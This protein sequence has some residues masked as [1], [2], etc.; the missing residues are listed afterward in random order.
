MNNADLFDQFKK[1]WGVVVVEVLAAEECAELIKALTKINRYRA[2]RAEIP[3]QKM[4][5]L[6]DELADVSICIEHLIQVHGLENRVAARIKKKLM[7]L[8]S[9][10]RDRRRGHP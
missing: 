7:R 2:A 8:A 10:V 6:V 4:T 9:R 5:D 1:R 3:R